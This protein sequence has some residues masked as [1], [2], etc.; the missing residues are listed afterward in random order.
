MRNLKIKI[1]NREHSEEVQK[2]LFEL[3][4]YWAY[5]LWNQLGHQGAE[6]IYTHSDWVMYPYPM[7]HLLEGEKYQKA[8]L[9]ELLDIQN[10]LE[11]E[12]GRSVQFHEGFV[13]IGQEKITH[14]DLKK[15]LKQL[16]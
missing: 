15:I 16:K 12:N 13:T 14:K 8:T 10:P 3:G 1:R 6:N 7:P 4:Y 2:R 5:K 11:L 9:E